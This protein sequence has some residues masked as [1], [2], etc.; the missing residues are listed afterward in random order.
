MDIVKM[1]KLS[2]DLIVGAWSLIKGLIITLK[3]CFMPAITLQYPTQKQPMSDR[4]RG[5]VD[6]RPEKCITCYQCVKI[7]PTACLAITHKEA[8]KKKSL[9][10]FKYNMELCCF[11]GLCQQVCPTS[12]VYMNKIYEI[13]VYDRNKLDINLLNPEKYIEWTNTN[14]K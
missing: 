3:N 6:L 7:C 4:F 11:C 5:L 12:A 2:K 14:I 1:M 8:D 9:E 13:S 10:T